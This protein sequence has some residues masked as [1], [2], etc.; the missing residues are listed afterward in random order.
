MLEN[1]TLLRV[2]Q[3]LLSEREMLLKIAQKHG[4]DPR[5]RIQR[6]SMTESNFGGGDYNG[7]FKVELKRE[8]NSESKEVS[9]I[10]RVYNGFEPDSPRA[11]FCYY[12]LKRT[13]CPAGEVPA[14]PGYVCLGVN[15]NQQISYTIET[16]IPDM[17]IVDNV[18]T[19]VIAKYP[20]AQIVQT[21][22]NS[23]QIYQISQYEMPHLFCWGKCDETATTEE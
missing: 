4:L 6:N 19:S 8:E 14:S 20:L 7:W 10:L 22:G 2:D 3:Q 15:M 18:T 1:G 17:P 12:N 21:D 13:N 11:G 23:F 16:D 5:T 9:N